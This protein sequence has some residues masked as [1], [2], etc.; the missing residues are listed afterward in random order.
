M[1]GTCTVEGCDRSA[2]AK[3][4]CRRHYGQVWRKGR[5]QPDDEKDLKDEEKEAM[6]SFESN[7][8]LLRE[9][10]NV[11]ELYER[12]VGFHGQMRYRQQL[13]DIERQA[14]IRGLKLE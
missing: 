5:I 12:V 4:Y 9:W 1:E 8:A 10:R 13:L 7:R 11:K 2:H 6:R 3:G 14:S